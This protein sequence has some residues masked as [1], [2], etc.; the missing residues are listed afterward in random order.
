M[1]EDALAVV[2]EADDVD[3]A[4]VGDE[5]P[6]EKIAYAG[7]GDVTVAALETAAIA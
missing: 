3:D 2:A 7:D 6:I 5:D 1:A 4:G